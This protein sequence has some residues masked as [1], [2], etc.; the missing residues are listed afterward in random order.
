MPIKLTKTIE[1]LKIYT[2]GDPSIYNQDFLLA[3][4]LGI[5]GLQAIQFCRKGGY[6]HPNALLPGE[7]P[8][9]ITN[10]G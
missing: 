10:G 8:E 9:E 3:V 2:S 6:W 5:A 4:K 1:I 7:Q